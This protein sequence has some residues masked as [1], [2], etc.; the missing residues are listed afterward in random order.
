[1]KSTGK[2][3]RRNPKKEPV[4]KELKRTNTI[5]INEANGQFAKG[6]I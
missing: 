1:M 6:H 4:N 3:A 5:Y 2:D